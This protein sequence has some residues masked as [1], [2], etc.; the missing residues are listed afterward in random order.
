MQVIHRHI[1]LIC[2]LLI[3]TL[4]LA[5]SLVIDRSLFNGLIIAKTFWVQMVVC[6]A[7]VF[8]AVI[9]WQIKRITLT[10]ID[11]LLFFFISW[12]LIREGF[13]QMPYANF[14]E[15]AINCFIYVGV[16][17]FI[18]INN[19]R[20]YFIESIIVLY[21]VFIAIQAVIGLLQLY[22]LLES[23]HGLFKITGTFHNPGPFSGFVVSGLPMAVALYLLTVSSKQRSGNS[24]EVGRNQLEVCDIAWI[25]RKI[26]FFSYEV[27]ISRL[28]NF[29]SQFVIVVLL[30]VLPAARSRAAW[31]GGVVGC[32]YIFWF[33]RNIILKTLRISVLIERIP[34]LQKRILVVLAV[35]LIIATGVGLYK[36]KQ[37]SADGRLLMWQVSWEM[38][39]DKP[40][41][42]WGQGGFE[43][44]YGNYQT[45]WFRTGK[46][47]KAQEM[48]AGTPEA[49]FN[50]L[51][52][53]WLNYGLIG[54]A[55]IFASLIVLFCRGSQVTMENPKEKLSDS[56]R[57][58]SASFAI[59]L[60]SAFITMLVFSTFSY[61]VDVTPIIIQL[62]IL[63]GLIKLPVLR[64]INFTNGC[65]KFA[66]IGIVSSILIVL[67][68]FT[69]IQL[70]NK[71]KGYQLWQEAT[72]TYNYKLYKDSAQEYE[73]ALEYLPKNGLLMQVY[74]KCLTMNEEYSKAIPVLVKAK[75]YR[76]DPFLLC[77]LGDAYT[78]LE[79]YDKGER[80]YKQAGD[81]VPCQFYP[82]LLLAK[83]YYKKEDQSSF[84]DIY[85]ELMDKKVKVHSQ[86]IDEIKEELQKMKTELD[87]I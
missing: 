32:A 5:S 7:F 14:T 22:G 84:N 69:G 20:K 21:L 9:V 13:S 39:K 62:L 29:F 83:L 75:T 65:R 73:V 63:V 67:G 45:D 71:Y 64:Q 80:N 18:R 74:G 30:L 78:Q 72:V 52:R 33:N 41:L 61:P 51:I 40:L 2:A 25:H 56:L 47:T 38:I 11:L 82:N 35:I 34:A 81:M 79:Q 26:Y 77:A 37:G 1:I 16:Y 10:A 50:E 17:L 57:K 60:K 58:S 8:V 54:M 46:G 28:L 27:E 43:A 24:S 4:F 70:K 44:Q 6:M 59:S 48:V 31:L 76:C 85:N 19:Q 55:F 3:T 66:S 36:Y 86:A 49:P 42:G 53:V 15:V 12:V 23:N 87:N 68:G